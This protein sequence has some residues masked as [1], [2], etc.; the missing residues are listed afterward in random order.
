MS[1]TRRGVEDL[2]ADLT[3]DEKALLTAGRDGWST[4]PIERLGIPSVRMT[5]GP[6]GA[7]GSS[8]LG[9]GDVTSVCTPCGSALGATWNP[10]LVE[11]VG[12]MIGED[13]R[14]KGC[15]VLLAPCVNIQ[16]TPLAGRTFESLSEDPLLAGQIAAA[17]VRGV[18][19]RSVAAVV[20]HLAGNE[21]EFERYSI[22]VLIDERALR[23]IYLVPFE[24]AISEGGALGVMAAYNQLN[25]RFCSENEPLLQG[26]LREEWGFDGFVVSDWYANGS[27][28]GCALAGLDLE[29]PGPGRFFGPALAAAVRR[30]EVA[31]A[32]VDQKARRL[33]KVFFK[34][35]ALD[36][37]EHEE[38]SLDSGEHRAL[39]RRAASEGMVLLRND[40]LLPFDL[41]RI[42]TLAVVGP[43]A[44]RC[45]IM[46]GGSA[47]LRPHYRLSPLDAIR[48]RL[49]R[50]VAIL[51]EPGC[52]IDRAAPPVV[53]PE[54]ASP[55]FSIHLYAGSKLAGDCACTLQREDG[56]LLFFEQPAPGLDFDDFSFRARGAFT[57][58]HDGAHLFT[59]VQAGRTR[60]YV[61][62]ALVLDSAA[63]PPAS[64]GHRRR[65]P[66]GEETMTHV[67]LAAGRGVDLLVEYSSAGTSASGRGVRLGVAAPEAPGMLERAV[68]AARAADCVIAVVGTNDG[69]E[70]EGFDR[71]SMSLPGGQDELVVRV[72]EA[73]PNTVVAVNAGAPVT[74]DWAER[75]RALLYTWFG[76][77]EMAAA[78][79]DVLIGTAEPAGRLP[80]TFPR[81]I[82]QTPAYASPPSPDGSVRYAEGVLVGYRWFETGGVPPRYPFGHGLSY[83]RFE[84]A[85]PELATRLLASHETLAIDVPVKNVGDRRGA[86]VLQCYVAPP[87]TRRL[88]PPKEL[89]AFAK[90]WLDPGERVVAR[91]ELSERA[92]AHWDPGD[93]AWRVEPGIYKLHIG[94]SSSDIVHTASI[95]VMA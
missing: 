69:W 41:G 95:E 3:L 4:A 49:G 8:L 43:N 30:G 70:S 48:E 5:D 72:L 34:L 15:R 82:E 56:L 92:W 13:A 85:A 63:D 54:L 94:R 84:I 55:G 80:M 59:V 73:N 7:R 1:R 87:D 74:L 16:R 65:G 93:G 39:A 29:M 22:D 23:E 58:R 53:A 17:Y 31:E 86:E 52:R 19:S 67:A 2:V 40:G 46:G 61:D 24:L 38:R 37:P 88:R 75:T 26:L 11:R 33:L 25:G 78:L 62:G 12:A 66:Y 9:A 83:T 42:R 10:A 57:P 68:D 45:E 50:Q 90:V 60:L 81:V 32:F 44:D 77:Q 20:K 91:L 47:K 14:T 36:D 64:G 27:T 21:S 6:N 89:K 79:V 51:H 18:Q 71:T 35:G 76:G 28:L